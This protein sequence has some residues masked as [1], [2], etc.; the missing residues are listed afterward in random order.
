MF[1]VGEGLNV[2]ALC[3]NGW[4]FGTGSIGRNGKGVFGKVSISVVNVQSTL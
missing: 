1:V 4:A 3:A 2:M